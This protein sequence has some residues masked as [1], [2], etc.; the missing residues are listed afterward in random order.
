MSLFLMPSS[1]RRADDGG[2][3]RDRTGDPLLAKQVLSQLSYSP[4][5]VPE[6]AVK[7]LQRQSLRWPSRFDSKSVVG[8]GRV[9]LPTSP[10]SGV[11]SNQLSYRPIALRLVRLTSR[12]SPIPDLA[13]QPR[14]LSGTAQ[15]TCVGRSRERECCFAFILR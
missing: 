3:D 10:L 6:P 8:L 4:D 14:H 13:P 1:W 7:P 9:E 11:R 2:A 15:A 12:A 5:S